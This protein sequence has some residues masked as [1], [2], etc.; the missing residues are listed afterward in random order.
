MVDWR[1]KLPDT[2]NEAINELVRRT[3]KH[4]DAYEDSPHVRTA[5][6]WCA[7]VELDKEIKFT[8]ERMMNLE[9]QLQAIKSALRR[10]GEQLGKV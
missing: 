7:L 6:L 2:S 3:E 4:K 5:Q 10:S 9:T 8:Q 1:N